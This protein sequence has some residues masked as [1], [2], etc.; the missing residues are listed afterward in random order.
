METSR[1]LKRRRSVSPS[2][3][4]SESMS[5]PRAMRHLPKRRLVE[6]SHVEKPLLR[7][8]LLSHRGGYSGVL[9]SSS[10]TNT[11]GTSE[12]ELGTALSDVESEVRAGDHYEVSPDRDDEEIDVVLMTSKTAPSSPCGPVYV[13]EKGKA[14][15]P[16]EHGE[17]SRKRRRTSSPD[18]G[19]DGE[20]DD[21][22]EAADFML[23]DRKRRTLLGP[24]SGR[25]T[26]HRVSF[27]C[28][29]L[30][31]SGYLVMLG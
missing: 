6:L 10:D 9:S 28:T 31:I 1:L 17:R 13:A 26:S 15:D 2:S 20:G 25:R 24:G 7:P 12:D 30:L 23:F 29:L 16:R 3:D 14:V 22:R 19:S 8:S 5:Y 4:A 21:E 18:S 11:D 27:P